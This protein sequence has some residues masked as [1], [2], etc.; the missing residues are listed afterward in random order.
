MWVKALEGPAKK[1]C[2]VIG[3]VTL[4]FLFGRLSFSPVCG[5]V[6]PFHLFPLKLAHVQPN[7]LVLCSRTVRRNGARLRGSYGFQPSPGLPSWAFSCV[8]WPSLLGA[9]LGSFPNTEKYRVSRD[10]LKSKV[11]LPIT[12][13]KHFAP[14]HR[15]SH[16]LLPHL[17][18]TLW[19]QSKNNFRITAPN[20]IIKG[21]LVRKLLC[22][23]HSTAVQYTTHHTPLIIHHS[24]YTT[25]HTPHIRHHS[26]Y[27]TH[28]TPLINHHSSYTTHHTPL[29]ITTHST[30]L[31][32][33]HS[34]YT[35]HNAPVIIHQSSY[36]THHTPYIIHQTPLIIHH[37]SDTTHHTPLIRHHS[38][39][40]LIIH[41]S[42]DTTHQ[43]PLIIHQSSYT[44][45]QTPLI[46]VQISWQAQHFVN[47]HLQNLWQAQHFV[48]RGAD[49]VA[50]PAP[51]E[52]PRADVV[53]GTALCEPRC[54]DFVASAALCEPPS[55]D[56]VAAS[57]CRL[58]GRRSTL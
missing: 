44:T 25:R 51:C 27:T 12:T 52:P 11:H 38:R 7:A 3:D 30:P 19:S 37:S 22:Y 48:N 17:V 10:K 13:R 26:S 46:K 33:H 15:Q 40:P 23:G 57:M 49:V 32:I 18:P 16:N 29:I 42:S 28:H 1:F 5:H 47:L 14:P 6:M 50:G 8:K 55:A 53:A 54:A 20:Y 58:R 39:T 36:T 21:S 43:T 34:S 45:H 41:H 4:V 2:D 35:T 56:V 9:S 24:S 31:I